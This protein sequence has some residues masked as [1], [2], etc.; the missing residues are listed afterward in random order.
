[1]GG[2]VCNIK[3]SVSPIVQYGPGIFSPSS[4]I[5]VEC[6]SFG[7]QSGGPCVNQDGKVIGIVSSKNANDQRCYLA[8]T[9]ELEKILKKAKRDNPFLRSPAV[10][11]PPVVPE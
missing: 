4:E 8:P 2:Y 11:R 10:H 6:T 7:G 5:V 1:M 9:S 3:E